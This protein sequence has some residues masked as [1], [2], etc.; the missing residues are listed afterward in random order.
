MPHQMNTLDKLA[1]TMERMSR[2]ALSIMRASDLLPIQHERQQL[3]SWLGS[4][5]DMDA[6]GGD[7]I[8]TAL[9]HFAEAGFVRDLRQARLLCY[10]CTQVYSEQ[11]ER[12]IENQKL[13]T[14]LL[15]YLTQH[16]ERTRAFRKSYRGLLNAYFAYDPEAE[17][18][19]GSGRSNWASL[20]VF[21]Q[22][23]QDLLASD[24]HTPE[25]VRVLAKNKGLLGTVPCDDYRGGAADIDR[26][27][28]FR[29]E[30]NIGVDSWFIRSFVESH[31]ERI[32]ALPDT[33]FQDEV[34]EA[35]QLLVQYP[36]YTS[37]MLGKLLDRYSES[38]NKASSDSL[39]EFAIEQ[40]GAPWIEQNESNWLCSESAREMVSNWGKKHLVHEFFHLFAAKGADNT[41]RAAFW[42][43]YSEDL[44]GMYFA[45]GSDAFDI[46]KR[47][48]LKFRT[49]AKGLVVKLND[50][51]H[52]LHAV[53]LQFE[54][55]HI[56]E[57]S[58]Q[59]NVAYFYDTSKGTPEFY[60]SKGWVNVG[61]LSVGNAIK[62]NTQSQPA[63]AMLHSDEK[64][65]SWEGRFAQELG[66]SDNARQHFCE[67]HNAT[68][69]EAADK[70]WIKPN[71]QQRYGKEVGSVLQGWGYTWTPEANGY[72]RSLKY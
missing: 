5:V 44:K 49:D 61:A 58:Q 43:L 25:W 55:C 17:T 4:E 8:L 69:S 70:A 38:K 32:M 48:F 15:T 12:L 52:N 50:S 20:H 29:F 22:N 59:I 21:L 62:G 68:Y 36:L 46:S 9:Q 28:S 45:L 40:W 1:D 67:R 65:L 53:I 11:G 34:S 23:A 27:E 63:R 56:V 42:N 30:L 33:Q 35:L 51:K 54:K 64:H 37:R 2:I 72:F 7:R 14:T 13:F 3:I 6:I 47:A 41:R 66:R 71:D 24:G 16:Q 57:F 18:V 26:I 10:G 39:R 60:L 31:I 19:V